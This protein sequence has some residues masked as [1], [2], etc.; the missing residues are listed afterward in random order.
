VTPRKDGLKAGTGVREVATSE[1]LQNP[2]KPGILRS[3]VPG[4]SCFGAQTQPGGTWN[5]DRNVADKGR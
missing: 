2:E 4:P 3:R 5:L 1:F